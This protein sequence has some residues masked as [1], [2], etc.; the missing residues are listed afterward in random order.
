MPHVTSISLFAYITPIL[1][2]QSP[3]PFL[4]PRH[5]HMLAGSGLRC[6]DC[7][8]TT[9]ISKSPLA[10]PWLPGMRIPEAL[11]SSRGHFHHHLLL[12]CNSHDPTTIQA[13]CKTVVAACRLAPLHSYRTKDELFRQDLSE[14]FALLMFEVSR[15]TSSVGREMARELTIWTL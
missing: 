2:P 14:C 3:L 11:T 7:I 6:P 10:T 12:T 9:S 8:I 13:I 5:R 15:H 1:E 4:S